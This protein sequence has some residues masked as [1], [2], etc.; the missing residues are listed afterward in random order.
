MATLASAGIRGLSGFFSKDEILWQAFNSIHGHLLLWAVGAAAAGM[1]A[2][3]MFRLTF[4]TFLGQCRAS[5]EVTQHIHESPPIMTVPLII[6]AVLSIIGGFA[7]GKIRR[8]AGRGRGEVSGGAA[9]IK[10]K[11]KPQH[12]S[13][14]HP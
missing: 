2:F 5:T 8:A 7:G 12:N 9:S 11:K 14:P 3:Y 1:T 10:K 6:L 13:T 4:S